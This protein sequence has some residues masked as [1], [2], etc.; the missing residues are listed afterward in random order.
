MPHNFICRNKLYGRISKSVKEDDFHIEHYVSNL[1]DDTWS[2]KLIPR[3]AHFLCTCI[4]MR[5]YW[6]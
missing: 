6:Y 3:Y 4:K 2:S 5:Q 1:R